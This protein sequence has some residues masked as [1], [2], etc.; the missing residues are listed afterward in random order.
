MESRPKPVFSLPRAPSKFSV[1]QTASSAGSETIRSGQP[2]EVIGLL[3]S[4]KGAVIL[5]TWALRPSAT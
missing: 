4:T 2:P 3:K 5:P 1:N